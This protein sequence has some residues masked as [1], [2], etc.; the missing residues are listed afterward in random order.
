MEMPQIISELWDLIWHYAGL[1]F[2][3]A[4]MLILVL[5]LVYIIVWVG[6]YHQAAMW[7]HRDRSIHDAARQLFRAGVPVTMGFLASIALIW[8]VPSW[9]YLAGGD[10]LKPYQLAASFAVFIACQIY[11]WGWVVE[12]IRKPPQ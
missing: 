4:L 2:S 11:G 9:L 10:E 6:A 3:L 12:R 1:G 8:K 7:M 5:S